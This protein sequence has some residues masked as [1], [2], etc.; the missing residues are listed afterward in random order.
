MALGDPKY[1]EMEEMMRQEREA[2]M[3]Y[4]RDE[5]MRRMMDGMYQRQPFGSFGTQQLPPEVREACELIEKLLEDE[6]EFVVDAAIAFV[7]RMKKKYGQQRV[8]IDPKGR[9]DSTF[10][11]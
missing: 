2:R 8:R 6:D 7:D 1:L 3:R 9:Y 10:S 4:E 11:F 5:A